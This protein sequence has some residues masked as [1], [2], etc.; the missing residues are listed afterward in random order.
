MHGGIS[1]RETR[2]RNITPCGFTASPNRST[3]Q[4]MAKAIR[5]SVQPPGP[6]THGGDP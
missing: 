6:S 4:N 3:G 1:Q 2:P 5:P